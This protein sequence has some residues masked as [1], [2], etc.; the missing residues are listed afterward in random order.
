MENHLLQ[1]PPN[2]E[3]QQYLFYKTQFVVFNKT[4]TSI[5]PT[6]NLESKIAIQTYYLNRKYTFLLTVG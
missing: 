4:A 5:I 3:I 1:Y 6:Q 2:T